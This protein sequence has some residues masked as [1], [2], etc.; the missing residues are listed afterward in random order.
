MWARVAPNTLTMKRVDV[1]MSLPLSI[2]PYC[3]GS[4]VGLVVYSLSIYGL[5]VVVLLCFWA[6]LIKFS[7]EKKV[8]YDISEDKK[9]SVDLR[10]IDY[11]KI[12]VSNAQRYNTLIFNQHMELS[13]Q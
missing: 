8:T 11:F 4:F 12:H 13:I 9:I 6:S 10:V 2:G 7:T 1:S 3:T 5:F